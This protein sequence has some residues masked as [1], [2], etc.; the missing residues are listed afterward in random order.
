MENV[1]TNTYVH[2]FKCN[3]K[4][5]NEHCS[6]MYC[7]LTYIN[8]SDAML[9]I[10]SIKWKHFY[11]TTK[12]AKTEIHITHLQLNWGNYNPNRQNSIDKQVLLIMTILK[13]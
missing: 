1:F 3:S 6:P 4:A 2:P 5:F 7:R 12:Y 9:H 11:R 8:Q 13:F 10:F